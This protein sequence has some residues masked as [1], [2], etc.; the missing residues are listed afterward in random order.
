MN[1]KFDQ[2][3]AQLRSLFENS[4]LKLFIRKR[5]QFSL[6]DELVRKMRTLKRTDVNGEIFAPDHFI[7][8]VS[9]EDLIEWEMHQDILNE[10]ANTLQHI[11]IKESLYFLEAPKIELR[12]DS[13]TSSGTFKIEAFFTED[14]KKFTD[15]TAVKAD[16]YLEATIV[17]KNAIFIIDGKTDFSLDK[18]IINVG[19][20]ST[21][22][23]VLLDPHVSRHHAQLRVINNHFVI[24]DVGSTGGL[25]L[26]GKNITQATLHAGDVLKIGMATLIYN[27]ESTNTFSTKAIPVDGNPSSFGETN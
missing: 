2:I 18:P 12:S 3:E 14:E 9:S 4:L 13:Q 22:D 25:F 26:N 11:G 27:Q 23:L 15:T 5:H 19:R 6:V 16:E 1:N 24:F 8:M 21:N 7:L 17:P 10:I 20:H